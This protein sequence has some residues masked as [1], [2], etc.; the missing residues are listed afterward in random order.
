LVQ[1]FGYLNQIAS[2]LKW[3]Y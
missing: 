2:G 3:S 1:F